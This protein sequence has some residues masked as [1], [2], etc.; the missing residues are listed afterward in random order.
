VLI[1]PLVTLNSALLMQYVGRMFKS[2]YEAAGL[3]NRLA[4]PEVA[5]IDIIT[6]CQDGLDVRALEDGYQ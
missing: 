5:W 4:H 1:T 6:M 3:E 2:Q